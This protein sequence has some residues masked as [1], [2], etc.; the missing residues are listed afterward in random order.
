MS[1][2]RDLHAAFG[3]LSDAEWR[4]VL[5]ASVERGEIDGVRMPGFPVEAEQ[6]LFTSH[7]GAAALEEALAFFGLVKEA[8][9]RFAAP[10]GPAT[11][12][13]DFGVGWGRIVRTF[14]K[15]V[16]AKN[17]VGVDVNEH[18]LSVCRSLVGYGT[19]HVCRYGEPLPLPE[20]AFDVATA[21]SVFSHLSPSAQTTWL[22]ELHRVLR[23][24]ALLV[25]TTLSRRF[26]A[27]C[28]DAVANAGRSS[29]DAALARG[30]QAAYP[31]W[32]TRLTNWDPA[33]ML[34]LPTGGGL[35][36]LDAEHYGWAMV[37]VD[38]ARRRWA[39]LFEVV[40]HVDDQSRLEQAVLVL[41]PVTK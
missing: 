26:V 27:H 17:I 38:Y 31:D 10:L 20:R 8:C 37:P 16:P 15:D 40:D 36:G 11:R 6:R 4:A 35:Q 1:E 32:E 28:R 14:M 24:G 41:R 2:T 29:F 5:L 3:H 13:L 19:Y 18:I 21:F 33:E 23:P 7:A 25:V 34:Y 22:A 9:R 30:V 39:E 12:L